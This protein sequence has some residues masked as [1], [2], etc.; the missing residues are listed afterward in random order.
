MGFY[1]TYI[2]K[3]LISTVGLS[4]LLMLNYR[5][6]KYIIKKIVTKNIFVKVFRIFMLSPLD[7]VLHLISVYIWPQ[8]S[9]FD[10]IPNK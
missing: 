2:L 1:L 6:R 10:G 8:D 9:A 4:G 5:T 7:L 3:N